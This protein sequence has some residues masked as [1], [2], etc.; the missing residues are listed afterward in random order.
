MIFC[1][2]DQKL[3]VPT[4]LAHWS[5]PVIPKAKTIRA[6]LPHLVAYIRNENSR[7]N[8]AILKVLV[9]RLHSCYVV[10][11]IS[12]DDGSN[13]FSTEVQPKLNEST[14]LLTLQQLFP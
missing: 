1:W 8:R 6:A 10:G 14:M 9:S 4:L 12:L 11:N 7:N 2:P 3:S 13:Q 5:L